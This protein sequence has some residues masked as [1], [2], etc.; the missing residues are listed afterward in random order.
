[1]VHGTRMRSC[2]RRCI[3]VRSGLGAQEPDETT[4]GCRR[5][6]G[7]LLCSRAQYLATMSAGYPMLLMVEPTRFI[8]R[9]ET[10]P[11]PS[12]G[13]CESSHVALEAILAGR[14]RGPS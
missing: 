7:V 5:T 4:L 1:M 11:G 3:R 12:N 10:S 13:R 8:Q 2:Y 14:R 6:S 9:M